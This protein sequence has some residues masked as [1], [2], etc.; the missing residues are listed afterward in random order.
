MFTG[1]RSGRT[2]RAAIFRR[3]H[4]D[5]AA[6]AIG[7]PGLHPHELRHTA[8]S[9]AIANG[10]DI[11]VVQQMLGHAS[12]TMTLD[13]YGHLFD[14]RLNE[15]ADALDAA[16]TSQGV[17]SKDGPPEPPE[18]GPDEVIT[19]S[20]SI[21]THGLTWEKTD[22]DISAVAKSLPQADIIEHGRVSHQEHNPRSEA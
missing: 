21:T 8:A 20:A 11:K 14:N 3:G 2:I 1:V 4:F 17:T 13:T 16:R 10:A 6:K 5:A 12:A 22:N 18:G 7:V 19:N 9:L 15:V